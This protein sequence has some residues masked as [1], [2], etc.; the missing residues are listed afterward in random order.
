ML[1]PVFV[2]SIV[3]LQQH[4]AAAGNA[5]R[6]T[7]QRT[8]MSYPGADPGSITETATALGRDDI[9]EGYLDA[10][11][12][13]G[14]IGEVTAAKLQSDYVAAQERADHLQQSGPIRCRLHA[15][16]R[17]VAHANV[18][19]GVFARVASHAQDLLIAGG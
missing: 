5:A 8:W 2:M 18:A 4:A 9:A 3:A 13:G 11:V 16:A 19:G 10:M 12:D 14:S 6:G 15:A 17:R 1:Y 7:G